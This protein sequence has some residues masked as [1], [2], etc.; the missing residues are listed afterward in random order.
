MTN[1]NQHPE[2][3]AWVKT[4]TEVPM[5]VGMVANE[6]ARLQHS[7]IYMTQK[8]LRSSSLE[9]AK[10]IVFSMS[11]VALR[12]LLCALT[13]VSPL[14][15]EQKEEIIAF[16]KEFDRIRIKRNDIVHGLWGLSDHEKG[17]PSLRT[18]KARPRLSDDLAPKDKKW[19]IQTINEIQS[20]RSKA[21]YIFDN[22]DSMYP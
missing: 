12:D 6:W 7:M 9:C 19:I 22:M 3:P 14:T 15:E 21:I 13:D 18:T 2:E 10:I 1:D 4:M 11:P 16:T 8:L 17:T 5:Y 20:L